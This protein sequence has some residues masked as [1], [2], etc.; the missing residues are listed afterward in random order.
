MALDQSALLELT[1][2]L[3]TADGGD[4]MRTL[5]ATILQALVDAEATAHIGAG[6]Y[7]RTDTRTTSRN[8]TRDKTV[9]T[10]SGDVTVKIPTL[11]HGSFFPSL[12]HPRR[13]IDQALHAVIMEAYV[14]GVSTRKVDDLVVALGADTGISKSEVSRIC[15]DLDDEVR[16][17]NT[18]ELDVHAYPYVFLDAT[19]CKARVGGDNRG[20]GAKVVS[21]AVVIATGVAADGRREVLGCAVGDSETEV[22]WAEFLRS[23]R[24]RGLHGVQLV[25]SDHHRGLMNAIDKVLVGAAWQ[26]C[27][28]HFLRNVAARIPKGQFEMVAAAIR[29]IF[30]QPTGMLVRDHVDT[31]ASTLES[32]FPTVAAMLIECK[33]QITAFADFPEAQWKKIWSTNPIERLNREIKRRTDVVG[34]FPNPT[35]LLRLATC[36]LIE[37]HEEWQVSDRRYLS[38]ESMTLLSPPAPTVL[39]AVRPARPG[40]VVDEQTPLTA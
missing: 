23:L 4:I 18:R 12:L 32:Q 30:S 39:D 6:R 9:S 15:G 34:I 8:G 38:E 33:E 2:S 5:L 25:I 40:E 28:V 27:R 14:H 3:R 36:V 17:F 21:Q 1:E 22:F 13:R 19:Y 20:K 16:S 24:E 10:T 37:A 11:R 31:V 35:A 29:T 26:R 7:E